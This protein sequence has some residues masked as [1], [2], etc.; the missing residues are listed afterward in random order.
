MRK[1]PLLKQYAQ[2]A[3]AGAQGLVFVS[4][5][6]KD[7]FSDFFNNAPDIDAKARVIPAGVDVSRFKPLATGEEKAAH[8]G[9]V[10]DYL[11]KEGIDRKPAY[12]MPLNS[13]PPNSQPEG[14][15]MWLPDA[16]A[17]ERIAS[18]DWRQAQL[19]IYYGKYLWTKGV[20]LLLG[21]APL[22]LAKHPGTRFVLVGF[23][24]FRPYLEKMV[25]ALDE[26]REDVFRSL[27]ANIGVWYP[28]AESAAGYFAALNRRLDDAGFARNYFAAA[29]GKI[30]HQV[31]FTGFMPH[32]YLHKLIACAEISVA[33]S[34]FPEAFGLVGVEA[35]AS[36]VIPLQTNHTGFAE[37]IQKYTDGLKD[38]FPG[39]GLK[40]LKLDD[41]LLFNLAGNINR[42]LDHYS[43]ISP[44]ER[45]KI[46]NRARDIA[47]EYS[48]NNMAR[49][50]V[51][52]LTDAP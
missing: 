9:L 3:V 1:S 36:G 13:D 37:V 20:Q 11:R 48:W 47:L 17:A 43:R 24:S 14:R 18:V 34:I 35:I 45:Q 42:F 19:V 4:K 38:L 39:S 6:S 31:I 32:E 5:Y 33:P 44:E 7:E 15:E 49:Q 27:L 23:G 21:A 46:R 30:G 40:P 41:A 28:E 12:T 26:G 52:L 8:I 50:Y 29:K 16:A 22:V 10:A 25:A 2:E 51:S